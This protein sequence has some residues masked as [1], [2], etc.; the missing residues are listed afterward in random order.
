MRLSPTGIRSNRPNAA[1]KRP[2]PA[3]DLVERGAERARERRGAHRVVD[4]VEARQR[5]LDPARALRHDEVEGRPVEPCELDRPRR[6]LER[7]PR[8]AAV[9]AAVVAEVP[10]VRGRVVV[11][12]S[13]ADAVLRVGGVL[14]GRPGDS[15]VVE[16]VHRR[17]AVLGRERSRAAGR[18]R[19]RRAWR[20]RR[21]RRRRRATARRRAR[22]RRS[23]R[24][25]RGRGCRGRPPAGGRAGSPPAGPPRRPR[26]DRA[27]RRRRRGGSR[28]RPRR[29]SRRSGCAPAGTAAGGSRP[30]SP[31]SSSCRSSPRRRRRRPAAGPRAG[32]SRPDRASR[33]ACPAPSCR[34]PF[35]RGATA[36]RRRA[37]RRSQRRAGREA[38]RPEGM[39]PRASLDG[40]NLR[41]L[42]RVLTLPG[43][44]RPPFRHRV[45]ELHLFCGP[46]ACLRVD[47]RGRQRCGL[48]E[49]LVAAI[50]RTR[51]G[52]GARVASLVRTLSGVVA[53]V[54][55]AR[56]LPRS[57]SSAPWR[58]RL[59]RQASGATG[60]AGA[61]AT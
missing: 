18:R 51:F 52:D 1:L 39:R 9:R 43:R 27:R 4:V 50:A 35:R 40:V 53:A 11:R 6:H 32:R 41:C 24:A 57:L 21:A 29:G 37:P 61:S 46:H 33:G 56:L 23:G 15:R 60:T 55:P 44:A 17:Q 16:A 58:R 2:S 48:T 54:V 20:P 47:M 31:R 49:R 8:V 12:R 36:R 22:A 38:A 14:E 25:G 45:S 7:R 30:P 59:L 13:A 34:R 19:S 28:R 3:R 10:D 5:E 26:G 42:R